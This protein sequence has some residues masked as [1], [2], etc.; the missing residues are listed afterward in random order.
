MSIDMLIAKGFL[1]P[2]DAEDDRSV[3]AAISRMLAHSAEQWMRD[4]RG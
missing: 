2:E 3:G 1:D 4:S